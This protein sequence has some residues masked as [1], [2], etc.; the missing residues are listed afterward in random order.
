M[1]D[2]NQIKDDFRV[3]ANAHKKASYSEAKDYCLSLIPTSYLKSYFWIIEECLSWF[4][5][6]KTVDTTS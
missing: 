2:V 3:W 1:I 5:W 4:S 6:M